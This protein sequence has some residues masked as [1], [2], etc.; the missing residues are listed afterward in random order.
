MEMKAKRSRRLGKKVLVASLTLLVCLGIGELFVRARFG[1]PLPER[2]PILEVRANPFRGWEMVGGK[3]HYTY[4]YPVHLNAL[5]LRGKEIGE[6]DSEELRI[7][8]LGDSLIYGQGVPDDATLPAYLEAELARSLGDGRP[9]TVV[10][11]GHRAYD[12]RQELGL[13]EELGERIAP[14][15]VILFW[16][17]NDFFER[18]IDGTF[19]RLSESG[20]IAFDVG[21]PMEGGVEL[22]WKLRQLLRRSALLMFIHDL[23]GKEQLD[24]L[25]DEVAREGLERLR[26]YLERFRSLADERGF[27]PIVCVI[28]TAASVRAGRRDREPDRSVLR[29]AGE[30]GFSTFDLFEPLASIEG[31][32]PTVPFDG[33]Y[34]PEAN[35]AMAEGLAAFL[36]GL[37]SD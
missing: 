5:G 2:L 24:E 13:L 25:T 18:D 14:D 1:S 12:T 37:L 28:P 31:G 35:H 21:A 16:F 15:V 11:S 6:K 27:L 26:G 20:P 8:A 3:V 33:H 19:E 36:A 9:V 10:N 32:P 17:G 22:R 23:V 29:L 30:M 4:R 34:A 7:L